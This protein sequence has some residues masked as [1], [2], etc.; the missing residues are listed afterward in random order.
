M[1]LVCFDSTDLSAI[2]D[3][4]LRIGPE[5]DASEN[6]DITAPPASTG[7]LASNREIFW[8]ISGIL[9]AHNAF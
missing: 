8:N 2:H 4:K 1:I 5:T 9:S 6:S 3:T 7:V